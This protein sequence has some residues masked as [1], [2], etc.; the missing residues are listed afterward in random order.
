MVDLKPVS[1]STIAT[2]SCGCRAKGS[3]DVKGNRAAW[4]DRGHDCDRKH[5]FLDALLVVWTGK[6][7]PC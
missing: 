2:L 5:S 7:G 6:R 4:I 3:V 1:A